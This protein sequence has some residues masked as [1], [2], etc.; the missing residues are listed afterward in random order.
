[1]EKLITLSVFDNIYDVKFN[2]LKDM[3]DQA[4]ISYF[5]YNL[6]VRTVKPLLWM[7]PANISI[8]LKVYEKDLSEAQQILKSIL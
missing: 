5:T 1:M 6:N 8:D 2:L 4:G 7:A 3:L